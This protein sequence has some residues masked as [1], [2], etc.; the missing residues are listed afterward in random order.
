MKKQKKLLITLGCSW[1]YGV[2]VGYT[3]GMTESDYRKISHDP[4]INDQ[5][6]FRG[7]LAAGLGFDNINFSI[8]GSSNQKQF[9]LAKEFFFSDKFKNLK[10]NYK[11]VVVLWGITSTARN[12]FFDSKAK[13]YKSFFYDPG[14]TNNDYKDWPLAKDFLLYSYDH[15]TS[16][17]ELAAEIRMFNVLFEHLKIK[18]IW[19]D[20]FNHHNYLKST[21]SQYNIYRGITWP[22]FNNGDYINDPNISEEILQDINEKISTEFHLKNFLFFYNYPRD[23]LSKILSTNVS[24]TTLQYHMS[25]WQCDNNNIKIATEQKLLNPYSFHPTK[26]GHREIA[27]ILELEILKIMEK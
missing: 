24:N 18:C 20:T 3:D 4:K 7:L 19:F 23:I 10:N 17:L 16:I 2:G 6:S 1:T 27:K 13:T 15:D 21:E 22:P 8:G 25:T 11:E 14:K 5:F 9:R 12:E 26:L